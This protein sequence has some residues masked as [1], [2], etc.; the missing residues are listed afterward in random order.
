MR[1]YK[2][3]IYDDWRT[4]VYK[5]DS[6]KCQMPGCSAKNQSRLL[7][8]PLSADQLRLHSAS[9]KALEQRILSPLGPCT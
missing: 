6:H 1:N 7:N 3:P 2:D 5:R 9:L 4:R 8:E